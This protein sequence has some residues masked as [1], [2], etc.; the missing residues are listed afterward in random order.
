M[1]E[2]AQVLR[3]L[4]PIESTKVLVDASTGD[5]AAVYALGNGRALVV[6]LHSRKVVAMDLVTGA[7]TIL[8]DPTTPSRANPFSRPLGIA[9]DSANGRALVTDASLSALVAV[10]LVSGE[11]VIVSR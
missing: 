8:T 2:L 9:L 4:V 10:E 1:S 5:D 7:R 11:R 3:H 6:S